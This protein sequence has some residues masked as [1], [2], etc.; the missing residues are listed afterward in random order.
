MLMNDPHKCIQEYYFSK[1]EKAEDGNTATEVSV[2][3]ACKMSPVMPEIM[4]N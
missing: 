4:S 2:G 3:G 1:G